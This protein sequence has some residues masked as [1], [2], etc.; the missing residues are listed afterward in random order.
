MVAKADADGDREG[1]KA[2]VSRGARLACIAGG[3]L[4]S[5]LASLPSP[6]LHVVS[7]ANIAAHG[8]NTLRILAL[9]QGLFA[10]LGIA[11]TVL[12]SLKKA[13][14]S[15]AITLAALGATATVAFVLVPT[16]PF[17]TD[18]LQR[19]AVATGA[20]LAFG[21]VLAGI[22]VYRAAGAFVPLKTALR[23]G[24]ILAVFVFAGT[25][26]PALGKVA[27]LGAAAAVAVLYLVA[28]VVTGELG[29]ADLAIVARIAGKRT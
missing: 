20:G 2:A 16:A 14:T 28:L 27:T 4:V 21:L 11:T 12:S 23:V 25:L 26:L 8:G 29:K 22:A 15:A 18:Q 10:I 5:L 1:V 17:G 13:L 24:G 19:M 3:P 9:S 7:P 6:L